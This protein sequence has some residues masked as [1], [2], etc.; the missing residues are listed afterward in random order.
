MHL[1]RPSWQPVCKYCPA[2]PNTIGWVRLKKSRSSCVFS[3]PGEIYLIG[4][5]PCSAHCIP[6]RSLKYWLWKLWMAMHP[7]CSG[8]IRNLIVRISNHDRCL[9]QEKTRPQERF[10][11]S[12]LQKT[13][14]FLLE[15]FLWVSD[16][17]GMFSGQHLGDK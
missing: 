6:M 4:F 9:Y 11:L 2:A 1:L 7:T 13:T 16:L 14:T 10:S 17:P 12:L 3:K 5:R 15:L 8:W